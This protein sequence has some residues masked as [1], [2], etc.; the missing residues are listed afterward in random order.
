MPTDCPECDGT[1]SLVTQTGWSRFY[2]TCP[3][4]DGTGV[5]DPPT[6]EEEPT[7]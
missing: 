7:E 4:C 5:I 1:G 3:V 6:P 2:E